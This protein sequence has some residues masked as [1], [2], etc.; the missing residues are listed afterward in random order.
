MKLRIGGKKNDS[1]DALNVPLRRGSSEDPASAPKK[2]FR[3][4][5]HSLGL[6][7]GIN[8]R[9]LNQLLD[10]LDVQTFIAKRRASRKKH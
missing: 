2:R 10:Q 1:T 9:R 3:V 7:P 4:E 6:R 5:P 8:V